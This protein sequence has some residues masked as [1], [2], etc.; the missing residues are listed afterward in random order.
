[1]S[2]E[3]PRASLNQLHL[4]ST[5]HGQDSVHRN[6]S[7]ELRKPLRIITCDPTSSAKNQLAG[8]NTGSPAETK[9]PGTS[10]SESN[11]HQNRHSSSTARLNPIHR[12]HPYF[13]LPSDSSPPATPKGADE[14]VEIV[15]WGFII[16]IC[17]LAVIW[18]FSSAMH[19]FL[20][21]PIC[22]GHWLLGAW[23]FPLISP[24]FLATYRWLILV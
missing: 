24:F 2:P 4:F 12:L 1:M 3:I 6:M 8:T 19:R 17:L 22:L 13:S 18:S 7:A 9:I 5:T 15:R 20:F 16:V 10:T 14:M 11:P 21:S 23:Q